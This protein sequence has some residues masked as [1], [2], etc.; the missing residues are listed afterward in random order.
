MKNRLTAAKLKQDAYFGEPCPLHPAA[1]RWTKSGECTGCNPR[2]DGTYKQMMIDLYG[3]HPDLSLQYAIREGLPM[4]H[5]PKPCKHRHPADWRYVSAPQICVKCG[6]A[7]VKKYQGRCNSGTT[8]HTRPDIPA[9]VMDRK[10]AY[11]LGLT[12]YRT[13][14]KCVNGHDSPR[15]VHNGACVECAYASK[16]NYFKP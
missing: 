5:P 10:A 13:G 7:A 11:L 12:R 15:F 9:P 3:A 2:N 8:V 16:K 1:D 14:S 6:A 4:F